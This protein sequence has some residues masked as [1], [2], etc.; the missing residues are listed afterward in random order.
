MTDSEIQQAAEKHM[1]EMEDSFAQRT[2][3]RAQQIFWIALIVIASVSII[4]KG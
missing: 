4:I 3:W 1:R 2:H